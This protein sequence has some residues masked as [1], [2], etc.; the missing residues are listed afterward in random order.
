MVWP[1]GRVRRVVWIAAALVVALGLLGSAALPASEASTRAFAA[2][3]SGWGFDLVSWETSA[4]AEK[5]AAQITQPADTLPPR[6]ASIQVTEYMARAD[7]IG[8]LE[9]ELNQLLSAGVGASG[10]ETRALQLRLD[11]L[12]AQQRAARPAVEQVIQRQVG[13]L[14]A[15]EGFTILGRPFPP[16]QFTFTDPPKKLIVSPRDRIATSY[17]EMLSPE[18]GL[19]EAQAAE[20]EIDA[21]HNASAYITNIGGLGAFPTMVV[22][23]ASLAWVLSTVAHE[24]VHNYLALFPLGW[25]YFKSQEMTTLNETVAEIVGNEIGEKTLQQ[26]YPQLVKRPPSAPDEASDPLSFDFDTEMRRTREEV[27]RLLA[28]G[29]VNEAEA[30][31][32]RRRNVFVDNG[33]ALRVLNQAYFAF[34]GSYGVSAASTSPIGPKLERLRQLSPDLRA[35]LNTVRWF[36]APGDLDA[37]LAAHEAAAGLSAAA[38]PNEPQP[39][40]YRASQ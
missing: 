27:D 24:W 18:I 19:P 36:T 17:S 25:N 33:H 32:E 16:V 20:R 39:P 30:Y 37:A 31:M 3:V 4:L 6:V 26:Y 38:G 22:D 1:R 21:M 29:K 40:V 34:H 10:E 12:R 35:F 8:T 5:I 9:R 28:A 23:R 15:V 13:S 11:A 7:E 2:G 14:M